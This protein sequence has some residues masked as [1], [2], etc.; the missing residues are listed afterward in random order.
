[1][2][3][4]SLRRTPI[5]QSQPNGYR[6]R[7]GRKSRNGRN[8]RAVK[9]EKSTFTTLKL[10]FLAVLIAII[11]ILQVT[12]LGF[13]KIGPVEMTILQIPVLIGAILLGPVAGVILGG[14]FGFISFW[15]GLSGA[16][17]FFFPFFETNPIFFFIMTV[18]TRVLMGWLCGLIFMGLRRV[19]SKENIVPFAI[20]G[21]SGAVLNTLFFMSA[22]V[23]LFGNTE[24]FRNLQGDVALFPFLVVLV[25]LNG[26]I[27]AGVCILV[28][29]TI[30]RV[31]Y[32]FV[33]R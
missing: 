7:K 13:I 21:L 4:K 12:G 8:G 15:T 19:M 27:E 29:V 32:N 9:L 22:F 17:P 26:L 3:K 24:L 11:I 28:G 23:A 18:I 16:S 20:S 25:G 1:M 5:K 33:N 10:V 6:G 31:L 30:S 14:V 2:S